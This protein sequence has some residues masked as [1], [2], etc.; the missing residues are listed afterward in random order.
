[1]KAGLY[2]RLAVDGMKKNGKLY[3]PY[4]VT[5]IG[6]TAV[7]Y[8]ISFLSHSQQVN[9]LRGGDTICELLGF[10]Q[11][12]LL[13]FSALFLF[14]SNTFLM[15][16]RNREFGLYNIMGMSK[17]NISKIVFFETLYMYLVSLVSGL[18]VGAVLSKAAELLITRITHAETVSYD[19]QFTAEP[20]ILISAVFAVIFLLLLLNSLRH[21][22]VS[23]PV[24]LLHSG[25]AGEKKPK[26]NLLSGLAGII[27]LAAAYGIAVSVKNPID[28][29]YFFF[30]AVILVIIATYLLF[31]SGSV[32]LC[33]I[34]KKNKKYYYKSNHFFSVSSMMFRMKRNGA[35][36]ASICILATMVLV[37]MT[38]SATLYFGSEE[39]MRARYPYELEISA[40][41]DS[42]S[43]LEAKSGVIQDRLDAVFEKQNIPVKEKINIRYVE[44]TGM[45]T[46]DGIELDA[47]VI[48]TK[49]NLFDTLSQF[50]FFNL[51][52]YNRFSGQNVKLDSKEALIVPLRDNKLADRKVLDFGN[53]LKLNIAG[54]GKKFFV[55]GEMSVNV[56]DGY[57]II[58]KNFDEI[59]TLETL[60]D[61]NGDQAALMKYYNGYNIDADDE[62]QIKTESIISNEIFPDMKNY[63]AT[64]CTVDSIAAQKDDYYGTYGGIFFLGII[65]SLVFM[66]ATVMII[67]YKQ[68]TEGYE[69]CSK[70][71]I[72]KKVGMTNADI[73]K[74]VNSQMLTVFFAPIIMAVLHLCFAF[75]MI[76]KLLILFNL[77]NLSVI[78]ITTGITTVVFA[79]FYAVVY[80]ITSHEY[81]RIVSG[82]KKK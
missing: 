68:I 52:D 41:Y 31:M 43:E 45:D 53:G 15:K 7:S 24:E 35:G 8:I 19:F 22:S 82:T 6:L 33:H 28:S 44:I 3:F 59:K 29:I 21:I 27:I 9:S 57:I 2:S 48:D 17:K 67:Y 77:T 78:L 39:S 16:R 76:R 81:Y 20:F 80:K 50:A 47:S 56:V 32:L 54:E 66:F 51:E 71:E 75:P 36:L 40:D 34:L 11:Y 55:P 60:A 37:M 63:G 58:I 14:Y 10:G 12:I 61:Y 62:T 42:L 73:K 26:A 23:N 74:T 46:G 25:N 30:I 4:I 1:M 38:G 72:M 70:Y 79:V 18:A 65:L 13:F 64:G 49:L 69:D 5:G